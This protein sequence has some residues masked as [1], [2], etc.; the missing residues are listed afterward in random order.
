MVLPA[1]IQIG[2]S[3]YTQFALQFE[4]NIYS[5]ANY[6]VGVMLP[7]NSKVQLLEI[8]KKII[9]VNVEKFGHELLIKNGAKYTGGDSIVAFNQI[10]ATKKVALTQFTKAERLQIEKGT[11]NKGM[12]RKAVLAA[13]GFPPKHATPSLEYDD[14]M[15]WQSKWNKFMVRF[16][17][18]RVVEVKD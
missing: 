12:R 7:I 1:N 16:K 2:S 3:Y 4:K 13:I 14:W 15:Y 10:F 9:R 5:T 8:N 11:V 17:N 18:D 6:R